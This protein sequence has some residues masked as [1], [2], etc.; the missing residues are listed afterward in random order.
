MFFLICSLGFV[1]LSVLRAH[2]HDIG[3]TKLE[4]LRERD[5]GLLQMSKTVRRDQPVKLP[6]QD[7]AFADFPVE[8]E[9]KGGSIFILKP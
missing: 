3:K 7:I 8:V 9:G 4:V 2:R 1:S 6:F 5:K